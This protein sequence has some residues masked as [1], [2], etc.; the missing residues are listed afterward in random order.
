M[1]TDEMLIERFEEIGALIAMEG[2]EIEQAYNLK[3]GENMGEAFRRG[4]IVSICKMSAAELRQ[5]I[6]DREAQK[7]RK[8]AGMH[9]KGVAAGDIPRMDV[10]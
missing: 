10:E 7:E 2:G 9:Y 5:S 6:A 4:T 3:P 8:Q 1:P